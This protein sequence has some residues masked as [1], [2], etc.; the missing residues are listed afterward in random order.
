V[1]NPSGIISGAGYTIISIYVS[2]QKND[3]SV[4]INVNWGGFL[5]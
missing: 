2:N 4:P 1:V 3:I 5:K